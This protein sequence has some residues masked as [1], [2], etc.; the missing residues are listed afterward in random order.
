MNNGQRFAAQDADSRQSSI[1]RSRA[2]IELE[3]S[4]LAGK[5]IAHAAALIESAFPIA[6]AVVFYLSAYP[7]DSD[8]V[9]ITEVLDNAG[10]P[11]EIMP[12]FEPAVDV[13]GQAEALLGEASD[14]G[15]DFRLADSGDRQRQISVYN[16]LDGVRLPV[17]V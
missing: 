12:D 1:E 5:L 16:P 6:E 9:Q 4:K 7:G 15:A 11:M 14:L 17:E 2:H 13:I 3:Q 10:E 8:S